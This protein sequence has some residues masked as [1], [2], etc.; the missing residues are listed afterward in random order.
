MRTFTLAFGLGFTALC[1]AS[2]LA[3]AAEMP[4]KCAALAAAT[5]APAD[6]SATVTRSA[7][8]FRY[9][10]PQIGQGQ[11]APAPALAAA[12]RGVAVADAADP[13]ACEVSFKSS[14]LQAD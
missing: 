10:Y 12:S 1:L 11:N 13:A 2:P 7:N 5:T 4:A 8:L 9:D 6:G 14:S 3:S